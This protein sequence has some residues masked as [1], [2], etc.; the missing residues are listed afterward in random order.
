MIEGSN[1]ANKSSNGYPWVASFAGDGGECVRV[2]PADQYV[3]LSKHSCVHECFDEK[4]KKKPHQFSYDG[5]EET[6][7]I[8]YCVDDC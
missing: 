7:S 3:D 2:C 4:S 5:Y 6:N 1:I 8:R